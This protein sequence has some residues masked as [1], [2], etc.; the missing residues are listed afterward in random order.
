MEDSDASNNS[1]NGDNASDGN[2]GGDDGIDDGGHDNDVVNGDYF[3]EDGLPSHDTS[4]TRTTTQEPERTVDESGSDGDAN[5]EYEEEAFE[6]SMP[7]S[8]TVVP[9]AVQEA[10]DLNDAE[11][12]SRRE[13]SA[14]IEMGA[15]VPAA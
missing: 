10:S 2:G 11:R 15:E 3:E 9:T 7:E 14:D 1:G 4:T 12:S 13:P 8:T 5:Q 6:N